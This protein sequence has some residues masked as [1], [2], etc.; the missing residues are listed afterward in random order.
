MKC[1]SCVYKKN[2]SE[3]SF[4]VACPCE[5]NNQVAGTLIPQES[6]TF[7]SNQLVNFTVR[8]LLFYYTFAQTYRV[9]AQ[10]SRRPLKPV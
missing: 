3:A 9:F 4:L 5:K 7:R 2:N 8:V 1:C 6:R 10:N